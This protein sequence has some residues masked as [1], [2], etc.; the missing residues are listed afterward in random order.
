M[1]DRSMKTAE[2]IAEEIVTLVGSELADGV[3]VYVSPETMTKIVLLIRSYADIV[4]KICLQAQSHE[5]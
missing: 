4:C 1:S 5:P 2:G 3:D